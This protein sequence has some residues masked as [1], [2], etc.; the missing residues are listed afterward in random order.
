VLICMTCIQVV[1]NVHKIIISEIDTGSHGNDDDD[2][3]WQAGQKQ[4]Q[5]KTSRNERTSQT[6]RIQDLERQV[7]HV[8]LV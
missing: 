8:S 2:E 4:L 6:K 1:C 7:L 5:V 3:C